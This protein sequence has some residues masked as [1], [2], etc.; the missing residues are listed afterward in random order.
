MVFFQRQSEP[1]PKTDEGKLLYQLISAGFQ[2]S[3]QEHEVIISVWLKYVLS[4]TE[5]F[6]IEFE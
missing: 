5:T 1:Y 4:I 6:I 3:P 2:S